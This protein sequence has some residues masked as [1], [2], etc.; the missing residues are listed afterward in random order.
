MKHVIWTCDLSEMF[1][2]QNYLSAII[3][4]VFKSSL[5]LPSYIHV[6]HVH[7]LLPHA[8]FFGTGCKALRAVHQHVPP[9]RLWNMQSWP[10]NRKVLL[11]DIPFEL[12][13]LS[14]SLHSRLVDPDVCGLVCQMNTLVLT[15]SQARIQ[16]HPPYVTFRHRCLWSTLNIPVVCARV[17]FWGT[18]PR[19]PGANVQHMYPFLPFS[20]VQRVFACFE[21]SKRM[22]FDVCHRY[23]SLRQISCLPPPPPPLLFLSAL[24]IIVSYHDAFWVVPGLLSNNYSAT[25]V[26]LR[27]PPLC[28]A[29]HRVYCKAQHS[30]AIAYIFL[31]GPSLYIFRSPSPSYLSVLCWSCS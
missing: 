8:F 7:S 16:D 19:Y 28:R 21:G 25:G 15:L 27:D 12:L 11:S 6:R 9:C 26:F 17:Y 23:Q 5:Y 20:L 13:H 31:L 3:H 1:I 4:I 24:L 30:L 10:E 2:S 22:G 29:A 18:V 14:W